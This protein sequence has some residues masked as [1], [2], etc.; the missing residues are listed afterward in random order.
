LG[1]FSIF[2]KKE[3]PS[4]YKSGLHKSISQLSKLK[5]IL[6]NNEIN[7]TLF[8][9][10]EELFISS[11]MGVDTTI[12]FV[13]K[14]KEDVKN[15]NITKSDNIIELIVD[16]MFEMYLKGEILNSNLIYEKDMV[17]VYLFVGVNGA[18]KTTTIG[19]LASTFN[20]EGKKT[21]IIAADT[22]R[23]AAVDQLSIW[24]KRSNVFIYEKGMNV[25][26]S[27]VIYSGL[28]FAKANQYD[29]VLIDTAGRLQTKVNLMNELNK[30]HN[31]IN[32]VIPNSLKETLL[33]L[34]ATTGQNGL[35]QAQVFKDSAYVSGIVLTKMDGSS[36]GGIVLSI[37][38]TYN[39]PIKF[40]GIGEKIEDLLPFNIED[41]IYGLFSEYI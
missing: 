29:C 3:K 28:E 30:M 33:V 22:F 41:Y 11:D 2:K 18:G 35:S 20:A 6:T 13:E 26:P 32:K 7:D 40:I 5:D 14:I 37:R 1:L 12:L 21:M 36:K 4:K 23:A 24:A 38:N 17:N 31:V 25:D 10:L 16:N 34:D 8:E 39:L 15:L 9:S 27:S 19:K